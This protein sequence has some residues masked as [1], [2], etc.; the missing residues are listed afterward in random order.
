MFPGTAPDTRLQDFLACKPC[1]GYGLGQRLGRNSQGHKE[2]QD[3]YI[4]SASAQATKRLGRWIAGAH[5]TYV[6]PQTA[7]WA[8][9][10]P[11]TADARHKCNQLFSLD[12]EKGDRPGKE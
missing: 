4:L 1:R 11:K 2:H 3:K 8:A 9:K 7:A 10:A 5:G 12:G 6:E